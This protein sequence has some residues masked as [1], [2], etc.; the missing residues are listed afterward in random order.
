[1]KKIALLFLC[2]ISIEVFPQTPSMYK[3]ALVVEANVGVDIYGITL[4]EQTKNISSPRDTTVHSLGASSNYNFGLEYGL[5]EWFGIG[6]KAKFDRYAA[7]KDTINHTTPTVRGTELAAVIN[8]HVVHVKHFDL[9]IGLD[10]GYSR[11]NYHLND[12]ANNQVYGS[13]FLFAYQ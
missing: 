11:L 12:V 4:K 8:A 9:P 3:G 1:M 10:L 6:V 2:Y 7:G 13:G 5:S